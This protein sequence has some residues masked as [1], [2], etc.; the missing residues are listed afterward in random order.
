MKLRI[1]GNS[2][3]FR[4]TQSE[5]ALLIRA[6]RVEDGL[7][8]PPGASNRLVYAVEISNGGDGVR[9]WCRQDEIGISLP[10]RL[11]QIWNDTDQVGIEARLPLEG[12]AWLTVVVE[13]DFRCLQPRPGEDESDHFPNPQPG[14][15]CAS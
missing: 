8:F 6:G 12:N 4:L 9:A 13:K 5:L 10:L 11:A 1:R 2:L 7:H 14:P 15:L 3:R